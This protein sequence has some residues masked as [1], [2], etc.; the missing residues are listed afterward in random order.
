MFLYSF[1]VTARPTVH[2]SIVRLFWNS[3]RY[4]ESE[5]HIVAEVKGQPITITHGVVRQML[6]FGDN[7]DNPCEFDKELIRGLF[8]RVFYAGGLD[9][10]MY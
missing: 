1:A 8:S 6:Q 9:M 5:N 2:F 10:S 4:I 7:M 3:A